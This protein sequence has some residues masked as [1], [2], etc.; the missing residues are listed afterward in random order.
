MKKNYTLVRKTQ[1]GMRLNQ[2]FEG[3]EKGKTGQESGWPMV[4]G[5]QERDRKE[6]RECSE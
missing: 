5:F 3:F 4:Q 1:E 6:K 2:S